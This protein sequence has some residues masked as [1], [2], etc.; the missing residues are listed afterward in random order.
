MARITYVEFDGTE[1]P[2]EASPGQTL[3]SVAVENGIPG[4]DGDCGGNCACAT[5]HLYVDGGLGAGANEEERDMLAIA[6]STRQNSRLGCQIVVS[7]EMDGLIVH[8]PLG[9]H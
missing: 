8:L 5:C 4:I 3:M 1:H 6:D 7:D 9:Q 2:V